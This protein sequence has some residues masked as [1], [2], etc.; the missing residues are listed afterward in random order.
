MRKEASNRTAPMKRPRIG[1]A[2]WSIPSH[3]AAIFPGSGTHLERYSR[4]FNCVEVNS[5]FYRSHRLSTW[6][7]W[8]DSVP[9]DFHFAAKAPKAITHEAKLNCTIEQL[10]AFLQEANTLGQKLGP[11][12][13]Q[14]PPSF[15]F[16]EPRAKTFFIMLRDLYSAYVV[17]EPRHPTWFT[18]EVDQLLRNYEIARVAA[19]PAITPE[20][21][22]PGGNK[23]LIYYRLHGSPHTYYSAYSETYLANLAA[24]I[25]N[26]IDADV[27]CIFDNTAAGAAIEDA[28][29]LQR[30]L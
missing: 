1:T 6:A 15:S 27:W 13:F 28:Q 9:E 4:A 26:H 23:R 8:A 18:Q 30:L 10:Q 7:R 5:S 21:G 14:L 25:H 20:A 12:L 17:L 3:H 29:T 19:D 2:G 22:E 11:I 24:A 16:D